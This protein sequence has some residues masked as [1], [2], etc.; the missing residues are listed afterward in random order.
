MYAALPTD[1]GLLMM[2]L[3]KANMRPLSHF[4]LEG[5]A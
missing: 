4:G 1:V 5:M 3:R 2:S